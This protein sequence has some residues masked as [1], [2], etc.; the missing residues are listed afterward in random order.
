MSN[1]AKMLHAIGKHE[2]ALEMQKR[3]LE[4][5]RRVLPEHHPDIGEGHAGC[6][7][8]KIH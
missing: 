1:L 3:T 7:M 6:V 5:R 2:D 8:A 4:F